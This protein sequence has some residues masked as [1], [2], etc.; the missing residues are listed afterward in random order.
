MNKVLSS[1][2]LVK[3]PTTHVDAQTIAALIPSFENTQKSIYPDKDVH[4]VNKWVF[5]G[6]K[7]QGFAREDIQL[8]LKI[9]EV[10]NEI[11]YAIEEKTE[12]DTGQYINWVMA[13][14]IMTK[15]K[16]DMKVDNQ[17]LAIQRIFSEGLITNKDWRVVDAEELK[18]IHEARRT[19]RIAEMMKS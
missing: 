12:Y 10:R 4:E 16:V 5:L 18:R 7:Q 8:A 9:D 1:T 17:A 3:V 19:Q 15:G 2:Y 6:L 11:Q 13:N 14:L